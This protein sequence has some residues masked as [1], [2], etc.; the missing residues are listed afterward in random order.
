MSLTLI[1][2]INRVDVLKPNSY[3]QEDKIGWLSTLDGMIKS[4]IIDTHEDSELI[5]FEEYNEDTPLDTE[6]IAKAP[7]D[8][9]YI[10]WLESKIDYN[11]GEYAKYNNSILR[12]NDV[13]KLFENDYN[14]R[15][16]PLG[17]KIKFF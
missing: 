17:T 8:E 14:R 12:F 16:M 2:A 10:N 3:T 15:H 7:Y 6:L 11:N 5:P 1:E 9:M 4:Q 13:F